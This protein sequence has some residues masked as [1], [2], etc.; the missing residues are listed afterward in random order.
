MNVS[1]VKRKKK[2]KK[3]PSRKRLKEKPFLLEIVHLS[4]TS[5]IIEIVVYIV[6]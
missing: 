5:C 1:T 6:L 4:N 2:K 3:K